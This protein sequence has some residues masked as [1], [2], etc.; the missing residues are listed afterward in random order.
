MAEV[1][2][3]WDDFSKGHWGNLGPLKA[4]KNQWGG[5]NMMLDKDGGLVPVCAS[6][7]LQL[8]ASPLG[9]VWGMFWAW[10]ADGNVYYVQQSAASTTTSVMYRFAPNPGALPNVLSTTSAFTFV[11]TTDPDWVESGTTIYVTMYGKSTYTI[12]SAGNTMIVLTGTYGAAPAGRC[13]CLYGERLMVG[14]VSD[15]RFGTHTNR[16]HFSGDDTGNDPALRTAWETLN[17]FDIGTDGDVVV[18]L[19]NLRDFLVAVLDDQSMYVINGTPNVNITAR[20]VTGFNKGSGGISAFKPMHGAVDPSQTRAWLF[21]HSTRGPIRFNGANLTRVAAFGAT[22]ADREGDDLIEGAMTM[23]GGPDEFVVHG[24]AIP[25]SGGEA[26]GT[27]AIE[28]VRLKGVWCP[29]AA[30]NLAQRP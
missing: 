1:L 16:I 26:I 28:L 6:R 13:I 3:S 23:I 4:E 20:R 7:W 27:Q 30:A 12:S 29:V 22:H 9:K 11:P 24:V 15:A 5:V 14:G 10:G 17:Y 18:G 2:A 25:R 19:Y 8:N 21:D